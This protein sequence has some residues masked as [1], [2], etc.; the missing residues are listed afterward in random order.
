M[1]VGDLVATGALPAP[2]RLSKRMI[3]HVRDEVLQSL[4]RNRSLEAQ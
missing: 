4:E 2:I 1:T 3:R